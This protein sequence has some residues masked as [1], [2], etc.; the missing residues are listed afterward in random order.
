[1]TADLQS[2]APTR[3]PTATHRTTSRGRPDLRHR[4]DELSQ[5]A[6]QLDAL[7]DRLD[8]A[9]ALARASS[10]AILERFD[11][12]LA[13]IRT[14]EERALLPELAREADS[15]MRR[16]VDRLHVD[17]GWLGANWHE[18]RPQIDG[19]ACGQS[20][21]DPGALRDGAGLFAALVREH[22]ALAG[23]AAERNAGA[24]QAG[25]EPGTAVAH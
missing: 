18:L 22:V 11:L 24:A 13:E 16:T 7:V 25:R 9:D 12:L 5:A 10:A 8:R 6:R 15:S 3:R 1:M 4:L 14:Q 20:W 19:V 2:T 23:A 21:V 17:L